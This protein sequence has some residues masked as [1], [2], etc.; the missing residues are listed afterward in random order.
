MTGFEI[1]PLQ[2]D[3][4]TWPPPLL[5]SEPDSFAQNTFKE[6]IP[7]IIQETIERNSFPGTIRTELEDLR[8]EILSG[9][10]RALREMTPDKAFWDAVSRPYIGRDWL[11]APWYWA[12]TFFYRRV[13][14]AT[15]YFQPGHWH[16]FDPYAAKKRTEWEPGAAPRS[17]DILLRELP[18]GLFARFEALL[19]ASLWGN[20]TDLSY[21][22]VI[23]NGAGGR[24]DEERSNLLVDD[25][26]RVWEHLHRHTGHLVIIADN[27]GTEL[28]V[29]LALIDFLLSENLARQVTMHLKPQ[30][31]FVSDTMPADLESGLQAIGSG[32]QSARGLGERTREYLERGRLQLQAHWFYTTSLFYFQLPHD[33]LGELHA[34]DLVILKGD[35]NYRRLLGDAHWAPAT[36]FEAATAYF[37]APLLALRTM[38]AELIVGVRQE[39]VERLDEQDPDWMVNARRGLIQ[40]RL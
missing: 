18:H 17:V 34:A 9:R 7:G 19:H 24:M 13:L 31:F 5:T 38:K 27:A 26:W 14:E 39:Q 36:P 10:I 32:G 15:H 22:A 30:P 4:S 16:G 28:L 6:R 40:A 23:Q 20:R 21:D 35:V 11:D 8:A 12:E 1:P 2:V 29:D 33:L 25:T 37:P 3:L